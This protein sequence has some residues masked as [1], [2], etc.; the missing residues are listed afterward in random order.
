MIFELSQSYCCLGSANL[1]SG[2]VEVYNSIKEYSIR[3]K[4]FTQVRVHFI[5]VLTESDFPDFCAGDEKINRASY[6]ATTLI[7]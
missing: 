3:N 7:I 6:Q 4:K 2:L 5:W 1:G